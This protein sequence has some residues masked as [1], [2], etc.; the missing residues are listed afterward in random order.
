[1]KKMGHHAREIARARSV[2][3]LMIPLRATR[4]LVLNGIAVRRSEYNTK[5]NAGNNEYI[6][7][8]K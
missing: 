7:T 4:V 1:M 8:N 5:A 3:L 6:A 2:V